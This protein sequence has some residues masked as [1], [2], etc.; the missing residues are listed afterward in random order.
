MGKEAGGAM[1]DNVEIVRALKGIRTT[2]VWIALW[3]FL[4]ALFMPSTAALKEIVTTL[5]QIRENLK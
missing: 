3:L 5:Q 1:S 2:L 4:I